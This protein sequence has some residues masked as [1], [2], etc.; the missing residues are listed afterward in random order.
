MAKLSS[1]IHT[2][3][4][5]NDNDDILEGNIVT[6][7]G[8]DE[9]TGQ[10]LAVIVHEETKFED[11]LVETNIGTDSLEMAKPSVKSRKLLMDELS[12]K[13][14][15]AGKERINRSSVHQEFIPVATEH[16]KTRE[17]V[18]SRKCKYCDQ[19]IMEKN[20][21]NLRRHLR[22]FHAAVYEKVKGKLILIYNQFK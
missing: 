10:D 16:P 4:E 1:G 8:T 7:S 15:K 19:V 12:M 13:L 2:N 17:I 5:D 22:S 20:P 14:Q 3:L 9:V 18:L 6:D 21:T 11:P